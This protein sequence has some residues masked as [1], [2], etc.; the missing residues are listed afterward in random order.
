MDKIVLESYLAASRVGH[1]AQHFNRGRRSWQVEGNSNLDQAKTTATCPAKGMGLG[2][3]TATTWAK[4]LAVA[5]VLGA[6]FLFGRT[7]VASGPSPAAVKSATAGRP[8]NLTAKNKSP[9]HECRLTITVRNPR[10]P[11]CL[12]TLKTYL[13]A[14]NGVRAVSIASL[15]TQKQKVDIL[16][17]LAGA[18][19]GPR[20]IEVI[21]AHDLE[22]LG[23]ELNTALKARTTVQ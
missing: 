5:I 4:G 3:N 17:L 2:R 8:Q 1:V 19:Q 18:T 21:K 6:A 13:L 7:A 12:K 20:V 9:G 10:C 22:I 11:A 16:I 15:S 23:T 14:L